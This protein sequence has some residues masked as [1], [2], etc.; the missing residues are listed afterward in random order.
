MYQ[1]FDICLPS[2]RMN[3]M[4]NRYNIVLS[5]LQGLFNSN[6]GVFSSKL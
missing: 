3:D 6:G 2:Q 1:E 4:V 5:S